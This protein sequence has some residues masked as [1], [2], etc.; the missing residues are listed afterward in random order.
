MKNEMFYGHE[1]EFKNL[2]DLEKAMRNYI[3]YYKIKKTDTF[4]I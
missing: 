1:K 3:N 2:E 4:R